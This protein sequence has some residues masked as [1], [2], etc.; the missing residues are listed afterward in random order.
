MFI[1]VEAIPFSGSHYIVQDMVRS[2]DRLHLTTHSLIKDGFL[3]FL[4]M[5]VSFEV[6]SEQR[7]Y[8]QSKW[9]CQ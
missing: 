8:K 3:N 2:A 1:F 6:S 4:F 9:D 7:K 5:N